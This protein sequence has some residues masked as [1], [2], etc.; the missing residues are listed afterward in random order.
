MLH[1]FATDVIGVVD[2]GCV[3]TDSNVDATDVIGVIDATMDTR[4]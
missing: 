2:N 4:K 1:N 3:V